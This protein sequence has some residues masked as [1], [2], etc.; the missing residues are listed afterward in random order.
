MM[1]N[2]DF[3]KHKKLKHVERSLA[4]VVRKDGVEAV[5]WRQGGTRYTV[6]FTMEEGVGDVRMTGE[7][8]QWSQRAQSV[9]ALAQV[10]DALPEIGKG[11]PV[12]VHLGSRIR[13]L[14]VPVQGEES[15][16]VFWERGHNVMKS[17]HR[18]VRRAVVR[19]QKHNQRW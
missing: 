14:H 9:F 3:E 10:V 19:I 1:N 5:V 11:N 17:F 2:E 18:M 6:A 4:P 7:P 15:M 8:T 12:E 13:G 16:V